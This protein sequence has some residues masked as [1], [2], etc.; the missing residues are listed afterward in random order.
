M[1]VA[2][3]VASPV[4]TLGALVRVAGETARII[5]NEVEPW[6]EGGVDGDA[7]PMEMTAFDGHLHVAADD[8]VTMDSKSYNAIVSRLANLSATTARQEDLVSTRWAH[9][10]VP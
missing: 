2:L 6:A 4:L 10:S 3:L 7:S 8:V 1:L 5:F 9:I